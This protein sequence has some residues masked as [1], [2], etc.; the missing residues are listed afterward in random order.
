MNLLNTLKNRARSAAKHIVLAEGQD[1]RVIAAAEIIIRDSLAKITL[2]GQPAKIEALAKE[3]RANLNGIIIQDP[4]SSSRANHYAQILH[5]RRRSKG[6]KEEESQSNAR[7]PLYFAN[8]MV[9]ANQADGA[10]AGAANSSA[11]TVRA[12]IQSIGLAPDSKIVSSFFLMI[13]PA[14]INQEETTLPRLEPH[15]RSASAPS[16][17]AILVQKTRRA[18]NLPE[19]NRRIARPSHIHIP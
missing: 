6:A 4:S 2:I 18:P 7:S 3:I 1:P 15:Y 9:A 10:V 16:D 14:K 13:I 12:A 5:E 8:L 17:C 11:D 19:K